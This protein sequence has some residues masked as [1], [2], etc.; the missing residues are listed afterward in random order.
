MPGCENQDGTGSDF[1]SIY[2]RNLA[3]LILSASPVLL[4][5]PL[6]VSF[7]A[8]VEKG[9]IKVW[10]AATNILVMATY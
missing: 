6:L 10:A 9:A 5:M 7:Y 4:F 8:L 1:L 3:L 2:K